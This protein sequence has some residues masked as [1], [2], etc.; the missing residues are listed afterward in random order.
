M[1]TEET[2]VHEFSALALSYFAKEFTSKMA[3]FEHGGVEAM[4]RCLSSPDPD[5]Q[6]NSIEALAQMLLVG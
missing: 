3:I 1:F 6:K 5:V 2:V 4:V